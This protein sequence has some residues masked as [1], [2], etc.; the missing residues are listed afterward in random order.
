M[1]MEE[2]IYSSKRLSLKDGEV[3]Y[4]LYEQHC[5]FFLADCQTFNEELANLGRGGFRSKPP[6]DVLDLTSN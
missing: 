3:I 4:S 6:D 2:S 1:K 5:F